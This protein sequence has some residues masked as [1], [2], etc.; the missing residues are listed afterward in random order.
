M[1]ASRTVVIVDDSAFMVDLLG[2]FFRESLKFEILATGNNGAQA[3]S[4]YRRHQ[5]GL[6]TVDLT[7][8]VKDGLTALKEILGEFPEAKV[9]VIS[10]Q[11]GPPMLECLKL[12][13]AGYIEKP[14]RMDEEDFVE[15]FIATVEDALAG[16]P[17]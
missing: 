6:L 14:L 3:V 9:L 1:S 4:L 7:M 15:D 2:E 12:G 10:S 8:P 11:I 17:K 16:K 13:A 5:P